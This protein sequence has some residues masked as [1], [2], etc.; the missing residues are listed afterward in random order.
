MACPP[1]SLPDNTSNLNYTSP[2]TCIYSCVGNSTVFLT[3]MS[4]ASTL[5]V[6]CDPDTAKWSHVT[7]DN[8]LGLFPTCRSMSRNTNKL[9]RGKPY[10]IHRSAGAVLA[11]HLKF[12][13]SFYFSMLLNSKQTV[14]GSMQSNS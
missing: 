7:D 12:K 6:T 4:L 9:F 5:T 3:E 14:K 1:L 2:T 13:I 10:S 8:P 11:L